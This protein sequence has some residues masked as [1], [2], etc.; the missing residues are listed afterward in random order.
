[1][2]KG[3]LVIFLMCFVL[4]EAYGYCIIGMF[5]FNVL[6]NSTCSAKRQSGKGKAVRGSSP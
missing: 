4:V 2:F 6:L 3:E 1:M 5:H